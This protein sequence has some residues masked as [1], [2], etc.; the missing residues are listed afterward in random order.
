MSNQTNRHNIE[1][2]EIPADNV[3][4]LKNFYT[5]LF[6]WQFEKGESQGYWMI[7]NAVISGAVM[8]KENPEQMSTQFVT[9]ESID[10]YI[11]RAQQL[12]AKVIKDKK[13]ISEGYYAVLEDPQKNTFGIWQNK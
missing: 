9:V 6:G 4:N 3:D 11:G 8:Q 13:E 1:H 5:S 2:F 7:K 12:G 10:N